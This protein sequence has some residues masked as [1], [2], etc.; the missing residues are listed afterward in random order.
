MK[1]PLCELYLDD[2]IKNATL[3]VLESGRYI[4][5]PEAKSFEEE[6]AQYI[7]KK[8]AISVNSGTSALYITFLG[9]QLQPG[10]EFICPTHT[11]IASA[12]QAI[13]LGLKPIFVDSNPS[14][15]TMDISDLEKKITEKTKAI[16]TVHIYG[17][18]VDMDPVMKLA[19]EYNIKVIEDCAQSHGSKYKGKMTGSIGD[20]SCFSF[21][22]SKIMNVGGDG[23]MIVTNEEKTADLFYML[24]NHGRIE[25]YKHE[26]LAM[27]MRM[28]EIPAAIGRVQL[29]LI[30]KFIKRRKEITNSYNEAL[31]N[32][33][34]IFTPKQEKWADTVYYTYVV[35]VKNRTAFRNFLKS[36]GIETGIHYPIPLHQQPVIEERFGKQHLPNAEKFCNHIVSLP[37]SGNMPQEKVDYVI[38]TIKE[39][40]T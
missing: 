38:K 7:H 12:S 27:N 15:Y 23:G 20:Y 11:F 13:Q 9:M 35:Q 8:R 32:I 39:Y 22:P 28:P 2:N 1:V 30:D 21:F 29:K 31:A 33:P 16:V 10:D 18:P 26:I 34:E 25:K 36:K 6:F 24:K 40:Y 14:N 5:G 17:H 4:N 37:L 3:K 19:N